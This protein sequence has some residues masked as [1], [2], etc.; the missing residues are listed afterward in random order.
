MVQRLIK[1][2]IEK[3]SRRAD[4]CLKTRNCARATLKQCTIHDI[5]DSAN[6]IA[7]AVPKN[8]SAYPLYES[9]QERRK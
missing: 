4:L 2:V 3:A 7:V 9:K 1:F 5:S 8:L 6:I